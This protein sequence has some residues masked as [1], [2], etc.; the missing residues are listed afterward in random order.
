MVASKQVQPY[1]FT[2]QQYTYTCKPDQEI[3]PQN[4]P[5][6]FS[7]N[8]NIKPLVF[9]HGWSASM[10]GYWWKNEN[11]IISLAVKQYYVSCVNLN[12]SN[13][14]QDNA[15]SLRTQ[16]VNIQA[17]YQTF[18]NTKNVVT[19]MTLVCHSKGGLDAQGFINYFSQD[20]IT[21]LN[22]VITLSTPFW[23]SPLCNLIYDA[24]KI[25]IPKL[26]QMLKNDESPATKNLTT[27]FCQ[28]FRSS[29]DAKYT[30]PNLGIN[31][32]PFYTVS[33]IGTNGA[34]AIYN[35]IT[36]EFMNDIG[37]NDDDV[38]YKSAETPGGHVIAILPYHHK[39]ITWGNNIWHIIELYISGFLE[40]NDALYQTKLDYT[41]KITSTDIE[42]A[43]A[44]SALYTAERT[45]M[46]WVFPLIG[47]V[48]LYYVI[49]YV[50]RYMVSRRDLDNLSYDDDMGDIDD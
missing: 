14:I 3:Y 1:T 7:P 31:N 28:Q 6:S 43:L 48:V 49:T 42:K 47:I 38:H 41:F 15:S 46:Y 37:P 8:N 20:A 19:K 35:G 36:K 30:N 39:E 27:T 12:P 18:S 22:A 16:L 32:I 33:G 17:N 23:G 29:Y 10:A 2:D 11:N 13:S 9:V 50:Y 24:D 45:W 40:K 21:W 5:T 26:Y 44:A 34:K 25:Y 4:N